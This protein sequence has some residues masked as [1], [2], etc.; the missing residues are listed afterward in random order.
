MRGSWAVACLLPLLADLGGGQGSCLRAAGG[1]EA[2][3]LGSSPSSAGVAPVGVRGVR[4][5]SHS[6]L[7][8]VVL[9]SFLGWSVVVLVKISLTSNFSQKMTVLSVSKSVQVESGSRFFVLILPFF[10]ENVLRKVVYT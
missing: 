9:T 4:L 2:G 8:G 10:N 7:A 3:E 6:A 5:D 1:P